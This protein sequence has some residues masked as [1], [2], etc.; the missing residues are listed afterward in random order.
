MSAIAVCFLP[1]DW[2]P[3]ISEGGLLG[4]RLRACGLGIAARQSQVVL[5]NETLLPTAVRVRR[6]VARSVG[7]LGEP[8]VAGR[9]LYKTTI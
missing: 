4:L 9:R 8:M 1:A 7:R 3:H 5:A 6:L 2:T